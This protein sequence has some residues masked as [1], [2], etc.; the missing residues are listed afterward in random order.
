MNTVLKSDF[1]EAIYELRRD[2]RNITEFVSIY[3]MSDY[4]KEPL[5]LGVRWDPIGTVSPGEAVEFA[6][7]L[8]EVCKLVENFKYNGYIV[9]WC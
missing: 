3:K 6:Q 2:V 1:D 9:V 8:V 4:F 5:K 7:K